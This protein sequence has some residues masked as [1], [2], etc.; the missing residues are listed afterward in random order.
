MPEACC[1]SV[2]RA[3]SIYVCLFLSGSWA[4]LTFFNFRPNNSDPLSCIRFS[5]VFGFQHLTCV[6]SHRSHPSQLPRGRAAE[7]ARNTAAAAA[8]AA[9]AAGES[10]RHS[11]LAHD[12]CWAEGGAA[13]GVWTAFSIMGWKWSRMYPSLSGPG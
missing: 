6:F 9:A 3:P 12:R 5:L 8:A 11:M 13:S 4:S 2:S 10:E 1:A 7:T